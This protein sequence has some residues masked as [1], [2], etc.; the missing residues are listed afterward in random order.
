MQVCA[1]SITYYTRHKLPAP[2]TS[3]DQAA[4]Y[5]SL[6]HALGPP[7]SLAAPEHFDELPAGVLEVLDFGP[8][9][10]EFSK[11]N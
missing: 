4:R 5:V 3:A 1:S 6:A 7:P 9:V 2:A 10:R 8:M 11:W